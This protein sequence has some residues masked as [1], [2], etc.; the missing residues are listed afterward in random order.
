M[1][2]TSPA[3]S[4]TERARTLG[5]AAVARPVEP[6]QPGAA[7]PGVLD[8]G[9]VEQAARRRPVVVEDRRPGR[10]AR[11][12][13]AQLPPVRGLDRPPF[14]RGRI[15]VSLPPWTRTWRSRPSATSAGTPTARSRRTSSGGSSTP[16]ASRGTRRTARS[17]SSW[18]CP[19]A[20]RWPRP[21]TRRR[22]SSTAAL[23]VAI[24]A[25]RAFDAGRAAQNMMLAAWNEGV[26]SC[27][28][29]VRDAEAA[30]RIVGARPAIVLS[31]GYRR[32]RATPSRAAPRNGRG[33]RTASRS[34]S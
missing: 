29:G 8:P 33:E 3:T 12:V 31:F 30:E 20:R 2:V 18:S 10:V 9:L 27:P 19:T 11:V 1:A 6:D 23:V 28:N 4:A 34:T 14:H 17:G 16:A 26:V 21:S 5:R 7:T 24:V 22:T 13:D 25:K 15:L 32:G